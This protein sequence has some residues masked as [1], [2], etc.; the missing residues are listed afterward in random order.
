[1]QGSVSNQCSIT[2]CIFLG[3]TYGILHIWGVKSVFS[4]QACHFWCKLHGWYQNNGDWLS[5][6]QVCDFMMT[7]WNSGQREKMKQVVCRNL[8]PVRFPLFA[9]QQSQSQVSIC[10][11]VYLTGRKVNNISTIYVRA[12]NLLIWDGVTSYTKPARLRKSGQQNTWS[13]IRRQ[14]TAEM[15]SN[16]TSHSR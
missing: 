9:Y 13:N 8:L 15:S 14:L 2:T 3:G 1:M 11:Q 12:C 6:W 5:F 7:I 16:E 10:I 4:A